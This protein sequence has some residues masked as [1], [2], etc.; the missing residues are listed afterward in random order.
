VTEPEVRPLSSGD[1]RP[2]GEV[3]TASHGDYPA[4]R[5]EFPDPG[6]RRRFLLPFQTAAV[7]DSVRHAHAFGAFLGVRLVGVTLWQPPGRFPLSTVRKARMTPGLIRAAFV[8]RGEFPRFARSGAALERAMPA[9][10]VWYLL[11]LGVHPDAHRRGVGSALLAA[12][13]ALVDAQNLPCHLHTSDHA[14]IDYYARWG[15]ELT[16]P[17]F[18]AGPGGPTYYGMTRRAAGRLDPRP[19]FRSR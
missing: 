11:V 19:I 1:V 13:L 12:G 9:V 8:A 2:A 15:F 17:A 5:A 10:P 16:Q 3:L 18:T 14:N 7:R 6:V 4:F